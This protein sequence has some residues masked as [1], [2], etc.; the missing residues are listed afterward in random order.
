MTVSLIPVTYEGDPEL[1]NRD[2]MAREEDDP[3]DDVL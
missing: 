2:E 1:S 3:E